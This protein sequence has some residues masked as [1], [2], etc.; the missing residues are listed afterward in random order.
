MTE[1]DIRRNELRFPAAQLTRN[2]MCQLTRLTW[3]SDY[4]EV[5]RGMK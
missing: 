3:P 2:I 5:E 1:G 4:D